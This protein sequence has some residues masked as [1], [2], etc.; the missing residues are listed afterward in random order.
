MKALVALTIFLN[1]FST[2]LATVCLAN[3]DTAGAPGIIVNW[4]DIQCSDGTSYVTKNRPGL[5]FI[6]PLST[7]KKNA[8]D[9]EQLMSDLGQ[10]EVASINT[11]GEMDPVSGRTK[12]Y[13]AEDYHR[14]I[15]YTPCINNTIVFD[16]DLDS[17]SY[18]IVS[19]TDKTLSGITELQE[20]ASYLITCSDRDE[21]IKYSVT[22]EDID[23][24]MQTLGYS[25]AATFD[26]ELPTTMQY[27]ASCALAPNTITAQYIYKN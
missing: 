6:I 27:S 24:Y 15:F 8:A 13:F 11:F 25:L 7:K 2:C 17:S 22:F 5:I 18:C 26:E 9:L 14:G 21:E 12:S 23:Q 20:R 1:F 10:Q 3:K 19:Q 4:F 16:N